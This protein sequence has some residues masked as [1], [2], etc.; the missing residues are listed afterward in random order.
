MR[1]T[2]TPTRPR[3]NTRATTTPHRREPAP[4]QATTTPHRREPPPHQ[5]TTAPHRPEPA[6]HQATTTPNRPEPAPHEPAPAE[7]GPFAPRVRGR[8][9]K[10]RPRKVLLAAGGLALA[11]GALSL[12]RLTSGPGSEA[13]T[14]GAGPRPDPAATS[15]DSTDDAT[16][17]AA[18]LPA[19]PDASPSSTTALGGLTPSPVAKGTRPSQSATADTPGAATADTPAPITV[20]GTPN[21]PAPSPTAS[22]SGDAPRPAPP[23]PAPPTRTTPDPAP[24]PEEPKKPHDPDLCVPVIGLCVDSPVDRP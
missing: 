21:A 4:H 17:T 16:R 19:D 8:H 10:P 15:T 18:S 2:N 5:A 12:L 6:P 1:T 14:L 22:K 9:R 20:P 23:P 7:I 11:T 3:E 24:A 13:G